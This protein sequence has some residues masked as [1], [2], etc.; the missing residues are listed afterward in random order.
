MSSKSRNL[1]SKLKEI[2]KSEEIL[3]RE[4][5]L[6]LRRR[7]GR[8]KEE[9]EVEECSQDQETQ[10]CSQC[11]NLMEEQTQ[12][13][14][15]N[16]DGA[17]VASRLVSGE[18]GDGIVVDVRPKTREPD[19][20]T[21]ILN[22]DKLELIKDSDE[23]IEGIDAKPQMNQKEIKK[24]GPEIRNE[25]LNRPCSRSIVE[26]ATSMTDL[27]LTLT[28][29]RVVDDVVVEVAEPIEAAMAST[30]EDIEN[31]PADVK[32]KDWLLKAMTREVAVGGCRDGDSHHRVVEGSHSSPRFPVAQSS[33]V[34]NG[35]SGIYVDHKSSRSKQMNKTRDSIV[36]ADARADWDSNPWLWD[37]QSS[38]ASGPS[39]QLS[40][41]TDVKSRRRGVRRLFGNKWASF[42]GSLHKSRKSEIPHYAMDQV[43]ALENTVQAMQ[44]CVSSLQDLEQRL[45]EV[46]KESGSKSLVSLP[47]IPTQDQQ[48]VDRRDSE[49]AYDGIQTYE[50]TVPQLKPKPILSP[51][52]F[53]PKKQIPPKKCDSESLVSLLGA[54]LQPD[55]ILIAC[56]YSRKRFGANQFTKKTKLGSG[57]A[58]TKEELMMVCKKL[59]KQQ[60]C[61]KQASHSMWNCF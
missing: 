46:L 54:P 56:G 13:R 45:K 47:F 60:N 31:T 15:K 8:Q 51:K 26:R 6:A 57:K 14:D 38:V 53:H 28:A 9:E 24:A 22:E 41:S 33:D 18:N 16:H 27:L 30:I 43:Y 23:P 21:E 34:D 20:T 7:F 29:E 10:R 17:N 40:F 42:G 48:S 19:F 44:H 61:E 49:R 32:T 4:K 55:E 25:G 1:D 2:V 12:C 3:G 36:D 58:V 52:M 11:P 50:T 5:F 37:S 35:D 39:G 59:A